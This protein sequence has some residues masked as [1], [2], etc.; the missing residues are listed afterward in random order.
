M[1]TYLVGGA[2]RDTL[3]GLEP[4]DK[5]YVIVGATPEDVDNLVNSQ[6]YQ[7]VGADFPVFLH[8]VTGDEYALARIE[9]KVGTGYNGFEAFTSP[10]LTIEDDKNNSR[11]K[12]LMRLRETLVDYFFFDNEYGSTEKAWKNYFYPFNFAARM[13]ILKR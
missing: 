2:V 6:G 7:Q 5:D 9:R 4:K 1:K 13:H 12:E 8:P 3:L 11:L 10:D